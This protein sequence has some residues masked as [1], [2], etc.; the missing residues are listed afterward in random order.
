MLLRFQT[1]VFR[2]LSVNYLTV[3]NM[4]SAER[5]VAAFSEQFIA[6]DN[7]G[8]DRQ[9]RVAILRTRQRERQALELWLRGTTYQ[10]IADS[11]IGIMMASG[12]AKAVKRALRA[13]PERAAEEARQVMAERLQRMRFKA[14]EAAKTN[15]VGA[16]NTLI[17]IAAR[18]LR[19]R[20]R[21]PRCG[22]RFHSTRGLGK[23]C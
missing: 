13:I 12:V 11:G 15:A 2:S 4:G 5:I 1:F 8:G 21:R 18:S 10:Q 20:V 16:L 17:K 19:L 14:W 23:L 3:P 6:R 9:S 7:I 22:R